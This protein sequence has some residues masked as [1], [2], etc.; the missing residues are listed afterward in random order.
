MA[1]LPQP[2]DEI[3][4]QQFSLVTRSQVLAVMS[5]GQLAQRLASGMLVRVHRGVYRFAG[6][7]PSYRQR[8]MAAC[9]AAGTGAGLVAG[10]GADVAISHLAA[11]YL[12]GSASVAKPRLELTVPPSR[13]PS[14]PGVR[15]HRRPLAGADVGERWGIPVTSPARTLIDLAGKLDE[16][17]LGLI[18][19]DFLRSPHMT[20]TDLRDR[21]EAPDLTPQCRSVQLRQLVLWRGDG[22]RGASVPEDW[23]FDTIVAAGLPVPVRHHRVT[24]DGRIREIDC[25]YP[26]LRV[27]IEYDGWRVHRDVRHFHRDRDKLA[28]LQ[29]AGWIILQVTSEWSAELL[30]SR[31]RQALDMAQGVPGRLVPRGRTAAGG[32]GRAA[33]PGASPPPPS[34]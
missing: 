5:R 1:K 8:A 10:P 18:V 16:P 17:L 33:L 32:R 13:R 34:G 9:L 22:H 31:V 14:V 11:A 23:L 3:A 30:V 6:A 12:W 2:L 29:L 4:R 24:V 27:G 7:P 19:D 26:D 15:T 28:L 25:A 20:I 21:M